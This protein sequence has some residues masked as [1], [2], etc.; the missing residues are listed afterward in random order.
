MSIGQK[1]D[2]IT[3]ETHCN[4]KLVV[5][6][7]FKPLGGLPWHSR[8]R[9]CLQCSQKFKLALGRHGQAPA[10]FHL[11]PLSPS[12]N[13]RD[14]MSRSQADRSLPPG[15]PSLPAVPLSPEG[16][17]THLWVSAQMSLIHSFPQ[18][19]SIKTINSSSQLLVLMAPY[20]FCSLPLSDFAFI[21]LLYLHV[22]TCPHLHG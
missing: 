21:D 3:M 11:K 17:H 18:Q 13:H 14:L 16:A 12:S 22:Y 5:T 1:L 19:S 8:W 2:F 15:A 10:G 9:I 7:L 20:S 6:S 4:H